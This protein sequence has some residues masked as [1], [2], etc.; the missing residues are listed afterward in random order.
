MFEELEKKILNANK[1]I[2]NIEQT[3]IVLKILMLFI[4][5]II[6][7]KF[8]SSTVTKDLMIGFGA[9]LFLYIRTVRIK[10]T[11]K[12]FIEELSEVMKNL[13]KGMI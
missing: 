8:F 7:Y 9:I 10:N 6:T 12:N 1:S 3:E 13:K 2:K 5:T 4:A 11:M